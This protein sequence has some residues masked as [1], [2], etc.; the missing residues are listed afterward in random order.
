[1]TPERQRFNEEILPG[2]IKKYVKTGDRVVDVGKP[3]DRWG[4]REMFEGTD[5]NTLDRDETLNP[6]IC[7][8][9]EWTDF[10]EDGKSMFDIVVC[11]GVT[12]QCGDPFK[13]IDGVEAML[14][15]GGYG[16]IGIM[17]IGFPMVQDL[18]GDLV[19]F[20]PY[21]AKRLLRKFDIVDFVVADREGVPSQ[22]Y[23]T[24]RGKE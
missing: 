10:L 18:E 22:I 19:R 15:P 9:L 7:F 1:M 20:T 3:D 12:E 23:A 5:Y 4:Y 11:Y 8:N 6:D 16:L 14:K 24:V 21:G 17:S 2:F 13:L